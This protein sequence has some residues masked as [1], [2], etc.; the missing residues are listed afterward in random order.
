[1]EIKAKNLFMMYDSEANIGLERSFGARALLK[2]TRLIVN[3]EFTTLHSVRE[4]VFY[5]LDS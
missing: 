4:R 5:V 3:K 1:M 2:D